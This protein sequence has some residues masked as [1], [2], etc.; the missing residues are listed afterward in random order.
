MTGHT[1]NVCA[2]AKQCAYT[3]SVLAAGLQDAYNDMIQMFIHCTEAFSVDQVLGPVCAQ[4]A[5]H[6]DNKQLACKAH[7]CCIACMH[8]VCA[9]SGI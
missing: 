5:S 3:E 2:G 1:C 9:V 6:Q 8:S 7:P 4:M